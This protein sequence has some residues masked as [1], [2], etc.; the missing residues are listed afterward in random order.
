MKGITL[1]SNV[2]S[3]EGQRRVADTLRANT[4]RS[5]CSTCVGVALGTWVSGDPVSGHDIGSVS[6]ETPIHLVNGVIR[7]GEEEGPSWPQDEYRLEN[8][9]TLGRDPWRSRWPLPSKTE[10]CLGLL[11]RCSNK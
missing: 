9:T 2:P 1:A 8:V 6:L 4:V 5:L 7:L 10:L 3:W 11:G